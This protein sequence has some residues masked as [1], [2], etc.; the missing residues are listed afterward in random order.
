[1][2]KY[3]EEQL[4]EWQN[5]SILELQK[6][7]KHEDKTIIYESP[8]LTA[9]FFDYSNTETPISYNDGQFCGG[10][11]SYVFILKENGDK[12]ILFILEQNTVVEARIWNLYK[13]YKNYPV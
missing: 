13:H 10:I 8:T 1:M 6:R 2:T 7:I 12:R 3:S 5:A 9:L 4:L 11:E